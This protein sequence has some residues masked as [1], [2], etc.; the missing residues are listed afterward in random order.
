MHDLRQL[1]H[2]DHIEGRKLL[3]NTVEIVSM[4]CQEKRIQL[5]TLSLHS[6]QSFD[7]F[8]SMTALLTNKEE[9]ITSFERSNFAYAMGSRR[10]FARHDCQYN[11]SQHF[12]A[13]EGLSFRL[14][15]T[16]LYC[17][18]CYHSPSTACYTNPVSPHTRRPSSRQADP[19]RP[20]ALVVGLLVAR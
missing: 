19:I 9:K 17:S 5:L 4:K 1:D 2:R 11:K 12:I 3:Q 8:R 6:Y 13:L 10:Y 16:Y 18:L 20:C 7:P 15:Y 14:P